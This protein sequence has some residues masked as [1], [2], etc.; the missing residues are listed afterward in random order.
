[1]KIFSR[2]FSEYFFSASV[3]QKTKKLCYLH[4]IH[5]HRGNIVLKARLIPFLRRYKTF[6]NTCSFNNAFKMA[7]ENASKFFGVFFFWGAG[8]NINK[9]EKLKWENQLLLLHQESHSAQCSL[10]P[11]PENIR[12][13]SSRRGF[14][15]KHGKEM[16]RYIPTY[17]KSLAL[18][19]LAQ[20][21]K[22]V[23]Q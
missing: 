23:Y 20:V 4:Y 1:M 8:K 3:V 16:I 13:P 12:N 10:W 14:E 19:Y 2:T 15:R 7:L 6:H 18:S 21:L 22:M 5:K 11:F 9:K 17:G